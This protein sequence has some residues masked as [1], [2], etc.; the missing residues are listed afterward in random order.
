[1]TPHQFEPEDGDENNVLDCAHCNLPKASTKA[2]PPT[3][4]PHAESSTTGFRHGETYDV[5][6]DYHRLNAQARRVYDVMADHGWRSLRE[7]SEATG[8]PEASVSARLRDFR[9]PE[10]GGMQVDRR[11]RE[12][13]ATWEYRCPSIPPPPR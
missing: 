10:F 4:K 12:G 9:K 8:D 6:V 3:V 7:I 13:S 5:R 11:R 2:H 1:M